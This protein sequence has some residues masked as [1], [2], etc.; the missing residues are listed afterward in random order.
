MFNDKEVILDTPLRASRVRSFVFASSS[1]AKRSGVEARSRKVRLSVVVPAFNVESFVADTCNAVASNACHIPLEVIVVNDGSTDHTVEIVHKVLERAE[2]PATIVTI[3]N[4]GLSA[5]R[6]VGLAFASAPYVAFLDADDLVAPDAYARMV[7]YAIT[8]DC[9]QVFARSSCFAARR[10]DDW[11]FFDSATWN[12]ILS[13]TSMRAFRPL[14]EPLVFLTEPKICTRVWRAAYLRDREIVFPEGR[15]FE[16]VGIHLRSLALNGRVGI[17]DIQGLFY[18]HG[19]G[20]ALTMDRSRKR[21]D[22]IQNV[23]EALE[24][25]EVRNL[26][27]INGAHVLISILRICDWCRGEVNLRLQEEFTR[28]LAECFAKVPNRW[29][30]QLT[31]IHGQAAH[32]FL[33]T[34]IAGTPGH[35][36]LL[37]SLAL[38][39]LQRRARRM[40]H[41]IQGWMGLGRAEPKVEPKLT[42]RF[43]FS[44]YRKLGPGIAML[45]FDTKAAFVCDTSRMRAVRFARARPKAIIFIVDDRND[46]TSEFVTRQSNI[47]RFKNREDLLAQVHSEETDLGFVDLG[48]IQNVEQLGDLNGLRIDFLSGQFDPLEVDARNILSAARALVHRGYYFEQHDGQRFSYNRLAHIGPAVSVVVPVY[49][50]QNCLDECVK[51]LYEQTLGDREIILVN[52]GATDDS[53]AICDDWARRDPAIRVIHKPNGGCASARMAG[54]EAALGEYVTFVDGDDW[55]DPAMLERLYHLS[56]RTGDDVVEGGWCFAFPSGANDDQTAMEASQCY[57]GWGG[58]LRRRNAAA[59]VSQPTIWRRLYR[60]SFL[61]E[62]GIGFEPRLRRF[63]DMPFQFET[64]IRA[65]DIAYLDECLTFYRQGREGQDIGLTDDRLFIHF[66]IMSMLREAAISSGN[67]GV[68]NQF[69]EIQYN[70]HKWACSKIKPELSDRYRIWTARDLFGSEQIGSSVNTLAH[71]YRAFPGSR[72]DISRLFCLFHLKG[73]KVSLPQLLEVR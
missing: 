57:P 36:R 46:A 8:E 65:G 72:R 48:Y 56:L 49:N 12:T 28:R 15:I 39:K 17:V 2:V 62:Y 16:D 34:C 68:Y 4:S 25:P 53:G 60:R 64:L 29:I 41:A 47:R 50:V 45:P 26:S 21:F 33:S 30:K 11:E 37:R 44:D 13:G 14:N 52:D 27:D 51:S 23:E 38:Y 18:R 67:R 5:A 24:C 7:D 6:N 10:F 32:S 1:E 59:V 70:T 19:R 71:L 22:V 69:L 3:P 54:L 40:K 35:R 63:D 9:D 58:I 20:G 42:E 55:V 61:K 73:R 66:P 43:G 31:R